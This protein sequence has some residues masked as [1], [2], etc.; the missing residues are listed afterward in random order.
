MAKYNIPV[1]ITRRDERYIR[2]QIGSYIEG[3][4]CDE[5]NY[6][7]DA[8]GLPKHIK[9]LMDEATNKLYPGFVKFLIKQISEDIDVT[10]DAIDMVFDYGPLST[11]VDK[12]AG[13]KDVQ[14]IADEDSRDMRVRE[15]YRQA[16][17][18]GMMVVPGDE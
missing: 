13:R 8:N 12:I 5:L 16:E 18:L 11:A 1:T 3:N 7:H 17:R 4:L 15:L 9:D 2:D 6:V 10:Q 14:A